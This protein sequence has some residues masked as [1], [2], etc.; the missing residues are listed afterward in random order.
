VEAHH[1]GRLP[2]TCVPVADV[3]AEAA[4]L[5]ARVSEFPTPS[6]VLNRLLRTAP[7]LSV[8]DGLIAESLA[9]SMLLGGPEFGGWLAQRKRAEPKPETESPVLIQ[10][11][12]DTLT[13]TLNRPTSHNAYSA[14]MR[15]ALVEAL[16]LALCDSSITRVRLVGAGASFCSG[17]D[18]HEF[19]T[20]PDPVTAHLIRTERSIARRLHQLRDR[21]EVRVHGACIGAGL[22]FAAFAGTV[23]AGNDAYFQLPE[24]AMGL[25]P[26][27][28]GTVSVSQRIGR[29][30]TAYLALAGTRIDVAT[31]LSWGLVD[32]RTRG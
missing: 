1:D 8:G 5:A 14:R 23:I 11:T 3:T 9:Y 24:L 16:D 10:R 21:L 27:A 30:R 18:L 6:V 12:E 17:G 4:R 28:G 25:V 2:E 22:E 29:W 20:T 7:Q 15:D 19:G 26:G 31:A 32:R 13:I